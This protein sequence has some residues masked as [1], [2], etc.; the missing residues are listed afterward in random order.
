MANTAA[1]AIVQS[2]LDYANSLLYGT[3]SSNL[4]KLQRVQNTLSR[5]I[6]NQS[7]ISSAKQLYNLHWLHIHLRINFKL[8][9]LTY[10]TVA[11]HQPS[12]WSSH[13]SPHSTSQ[14][15]RSSD[16]NLLHQPQ[17]H[18]ITGSLAFSSSAPKVWNSLPSP[19]R[20]SSSIHTFKHQFKNSFFPSL[21][22]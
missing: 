13:L 21:F 4:H 8:A 16:Q 10:K 15:L 5:L 12:Y 14:L 9:L 2:R 22:V 20:A 6:I 3:A 7:N 18:I 1:V 11:L 19:I 17:V